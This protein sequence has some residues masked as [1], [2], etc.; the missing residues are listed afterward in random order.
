M[1]WL[2]R[3]MRNL[4]QR[5]RDWVA[6]LDKVSAEGKKGARKKG[7]GRRTDFARLIGM[8]SAFFVG[9]GDGRGGGCV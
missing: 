5:K 3:C 1:V 4:G 9:L 8:A 7:L 6:R 2:F